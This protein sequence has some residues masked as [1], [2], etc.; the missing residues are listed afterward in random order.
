MNWDS[1]GAKSSPMIAEN[2]YV[3]SKIDK[4][5]SGNVCL[6]FRDALSDH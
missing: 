1:E 4:S 3:I 2:Q 5:R 6:E